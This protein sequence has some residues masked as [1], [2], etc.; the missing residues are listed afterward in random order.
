M[1]IYEPDREWRLRKD[2]IARNLRWT[3][4]DT[5]ISPNERFLVYSSI[6]PEVMLVSLIAARS[7]LQAVSLSGYLT[8]Y[9]TDSG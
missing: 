1:R 2:V 3:V 7:L 4:T 8:G 9:C 6:T 5:D